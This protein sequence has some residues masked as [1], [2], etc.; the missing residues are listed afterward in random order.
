VLIVECDPDL[1]LVETL[2]TP[3]RKRN[4]HAGGKSM[5]IRNLMRT[6]ENSVGMID[7]DPASIQPDDLQRFT[8][9]NRLQR[10]QI[11]IHHHDQRN[12]RLIVL[13]PK[14]E[15]WVLGACSE[16]GI[17]VRDYNLPN[18][19]NQLHEVINVRINRFRQLVED[20][21]K[22]SDRVRAL[23]TCLRERTA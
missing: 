10:E 18:N 3:S 16:A 21:M 7:E 20:L 12:N 9:T 5:V 4:K 14:L 6:Y 11:R 15:E 2:T 22:R 1:V 8:E 17:D 13:C 19:P 23:Q